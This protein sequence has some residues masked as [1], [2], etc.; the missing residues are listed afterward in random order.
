MA[1][2]EE[3]G[4]GMGK[5]GPGADSGGREGLLV[6]PD[7]AVRRLRA[8]VEVENTAPAREWAAAGRLCVRGLGVL[9]CGG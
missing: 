3:G 4:R 7:A 5:Q 8:F 6:H 9:S 2:V 1:V